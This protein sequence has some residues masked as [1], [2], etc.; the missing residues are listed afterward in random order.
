MQKLIGIYN[1]TYHGSIKHTPQE[2]FDDKELEQ[3]YIFECIEK[4]EEQKKL[5]EFELPIG[6][7]V[8]Y[9][10]PKHDGM[11]KKRFQ[12]SREYYKIDSREG[13]M[14]VLMAG[15]GTVLTRPRSLL[16]PL[17]KNEKER[18]KFAETFPGRWT[19]VIDR[20]IEEVGKRHVR[21]AFRLPNGGEYIDIIP[22][23]YLK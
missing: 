5:K 17:K 7:F 11:T 12:V 14:Y 23:S 10:L 15:D 20:V 13:N 19:G 21:V 1:N 2:M 22:K 3:E 18:M 9:I 8:R 16:I 4:Q 6:S